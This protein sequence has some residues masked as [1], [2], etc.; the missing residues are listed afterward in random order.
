M[1]AHLRKLQQAIRA[2]IRVVIQ[3]NFDGIMFFK[4]FL[5]TDSVEMSGNGDDLSLVS[6]SM[7]SLLR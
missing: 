2:H 5:L 7:L 6:R 3:Q 4:I 1:H